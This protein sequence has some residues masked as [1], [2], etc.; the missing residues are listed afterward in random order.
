MQYMLLI[1]A[2][3]KAY[4]GMSPAQGAALTAEYGEFT[5]GIVKS[6]AFRA[7][8]Q[9]AP[10]SSATTVRETNGRRATTDG[11]FVETKEQLGGYY[12]VECKDLDEALS[13]AA[14]IP[15]VRMSG[16]IEVRPVVPMSEAAK[17]P[18]AR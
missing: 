8:S 1:Y 18:A 11:P 2:D 13:I 7:G 4:A 17:N 5:Q 12:L 16:T 6:G 3:E 15:T 9:L 10:S 14:R